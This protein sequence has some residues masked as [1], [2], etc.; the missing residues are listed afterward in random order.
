LGGWLGILIGSKRNKA[1]CQI[2][3]QA[4]NRPLAVSTYNHFPPDVRELMPS[5]A[6]LARVAQDVM[7][8]SRTGA[9][10]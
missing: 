6:D 10:A 2:A 8:A 9:D 4:N 5:E 1:A 3:L 7:D